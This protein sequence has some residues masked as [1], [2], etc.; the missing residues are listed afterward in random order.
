MGFDTAEFNTTME[1]QWSGLGDMFTAM[2]QGLNAADALDHSKLVSGINDAYSAAK[3]GG[4]EFMDYAYSISETVGQIAAAEDALLRLNAYNIANVVNAGNLI[5]GNNIQLMNDDIAA[6]QA[7][8]SGFENTGTQVLDLYDQL[9][10]DS[11][12]VNATFGWLQTTI[13]ALTGNTVEWSD[14]N[15]TLAATLN[16][17]QNST[18]PVVANLALLY[19]MMLDSQQIT[20]DFGKSYERTWTKIA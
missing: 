10:V 19:E 9:A 6:V 3:I 15:E 11:G 4:S 13:S 1:N 16:D 12:K 18:N 7:V 5:Y 2:I 20:T 14:D 8:F 17:L